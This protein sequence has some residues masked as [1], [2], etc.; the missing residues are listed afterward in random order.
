MRNLKNNLNTKTSAAVALLCALALGLSGLAI[1]HGRRVP[2]GFSSAFQ[3][4]KQQIVISVIVCREST[5]SSAMATTVARIQS[6]FAPE[7]R[8]TLLHF[9][10]SVLM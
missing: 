1:H 3:K 6:A 9:A 5:L 10:I 2:P 4:T 8:A 7:S